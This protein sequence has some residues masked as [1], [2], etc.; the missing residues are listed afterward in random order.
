MV[1]VVISVIVLATMATRLLTMLI[2]VAKNVVRIA[3]RQIV[4]KCQLIATSLLNHPAPMRPF[5]KIS[6]MSL[7]HR[8]HL[9]Q[10]LIV[11]LIQ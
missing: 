6:P 10:H 8:H 5:F 2:V 3:P 9:C 7:P 11:S 4:K 1:L